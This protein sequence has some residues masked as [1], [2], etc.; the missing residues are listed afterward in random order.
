MDIQE[1]LETLR[2]EYPGRNIDTPSQGEAVVELDRNQD[3][4]TAVAFIKCSDPHY[5]RERTETYRVEAG[6]ITLYVDNEALTLVSGD[7]FVIEPGKVHYA[8]SQ[9]GGFIRVR[10]ITTP[11]WSPEDHI[12]VQEPS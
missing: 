8:K 9:L 4:S 11:A 2:R 3:S 6:I 5:H 7:E 12:L 10:V 1:L